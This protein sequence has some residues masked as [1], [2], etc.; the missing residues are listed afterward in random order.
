[1]TIEDWAALLNAAVDEE[2]GC[3]CGHAGRD[4]REH[5]RDCVIVTMTDEA[6]ARLM[7]KEGRP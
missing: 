1:V 2:L 6:Y 4:Y 7:A 3:R 5:E